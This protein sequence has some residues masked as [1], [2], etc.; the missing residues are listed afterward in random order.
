MCA[1]FAESSSR[2]FTASTTSPFLSPERAAGLSLAI[3]TTVSSPLGARLSHAPDHAIEW[4]IPEHEC[5]LAAIAVFLFPSHADAGSDAAIASRATAG[6]TS[7]SFI[8]P[9]GA[10]E[11]RA[12]RRGHHCD[13]KRNA[14]R[15][16]SA[17]NF[18]ST[19]DGPR[20]TNGPAQADRA[21]EGPGAVRCMRVVAKWH[22]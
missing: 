19:S 4:D 17:T 14:S 8:F 11:S 1:D 16:H 7:L 10:I 5:A 18:G 2:P 22:G 12:G 9:P 13:H 21:P 15:S 3:A 20:A 6:T